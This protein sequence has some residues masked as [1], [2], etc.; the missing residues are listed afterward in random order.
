MH[1]CEPGIG[2]LLAAD[3]FVTKL[4]MFHIMAFASSSDHFVVLGKHVF[5]W[6]VDVSHC[7]CFF[8]CLV[9]GSN[10]QF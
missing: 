5:V 7:G 2:C 8:F 1:E 9:C 4:L 6:F 3:E 10:K